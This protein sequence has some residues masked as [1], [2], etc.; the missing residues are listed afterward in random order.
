M[1][2]PSLTATEQASLTKRQA[3][4]LEKA[5]TG[6]ETSAGAV[7]ELKSQI[8]AAKS[9][10]E[11]L[12]DSMKNAKETLQQKTVGRNDLVEQIRGDLESKQNAVKRRD[13]S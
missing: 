7:G 10:L 12:N 8:A 9:V 4:K 13:K 6:V 5:N 2:M 11:K 3:A 1:N